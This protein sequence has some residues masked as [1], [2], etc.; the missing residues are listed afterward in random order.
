MVNR[1]ELV[2][3]RFSF[4]SKLRLILRLRLNFENFNEK[5]KFGKVTF[6]LAFGLE[7]IIKT[8]N[9]EKLGGKIIRN[10]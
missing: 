3:H 7:K 5:K 4:W 1:R 6:F 9:T 10:K 2:V 8:K